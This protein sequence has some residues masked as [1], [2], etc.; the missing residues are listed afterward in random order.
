MVLAETEIAGVVAGN[1]AWR[2]FLQETGGIR[3]FGSRIAFNA[4]GGKHGRCFERTIIFPIKK[5]GL[6]LA[7]PRCENLLVISSVPRRPASAPPPPYSRRPPPPPP[8]ARSSRGL[9]TLTVRARPSNCGAVQGGDGFLRFFRRAHGDETETARTAAH[10]VHHQVGFCDRPGAPQRRRSG[11]FSVVLKE[12][13]P[14]QIIYCSLMF[15]CPT[16]TALTRL[17]PTIGFQIITERK[18]T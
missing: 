11:S 4:A 14:A 1:P 9:A 13:F 7:R 15:Y 5:R 10:A 16:N 6:V 17:F 3:S 2:I 12:R 8:G 18:F